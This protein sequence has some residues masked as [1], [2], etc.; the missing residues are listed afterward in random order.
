MQSFIYKGIE[1]AYR[2]EGSGDPVVMIHGF[3]SNKEANWVVPS[4]FKTITESGRRA[5][6][7]DNRGHGLSTKFYDPADYHSSKMAGDVVALMDFLNLEAADIVGYSMGTRI[8]AFL[9]LEHPRRVRSAVFGGLGWHLV[10]NTGLYQGIAEALEA[11][12]LE[13][14][15]HNLKGYLFRSFAESTLSDLKAL[16]ACMRGSRQTL[17]PE[18]LAKIA[19]PVL[20]AVGTV[21]P[22]AGSARALA[23]LI[24]GAQVLDIPNRD[25]MLAVGD[26]VFKQGALDFLNKRP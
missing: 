13:D 26:K 2:D 23:E 22:I 21:D 8:S 20:V 5:I 4:W 12:S 16:A 15:K 3:A 9:T 25:H 6:A 14:V 10:D 1:I 18:Q 19:C 17:S 24:P 7:V 11:P